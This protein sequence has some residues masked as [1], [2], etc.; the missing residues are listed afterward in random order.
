MRDNFDACLTQ[1]LE[2]E[3][4]NDD[5]PRDPGGRTSRGIIQTEFTAYLKARGQSSRDVFTMT[6]A[7]MQDIYRGQ[8]WNTVR[9]DDLPRG[10]D[11]CTFDP[12]VNSGPVR[13]V[14]WMQG[15]LGAGVDGWVGNETITTANALSNPERV[16]AVQAA[17]AARMSFLRGL[18]TFA[19][20][21]RGWSSRVVSVEAVSV[22]MIDRAALQPAQE[23]AEDQKD[24]AGQAAGGAGAGGVV[25][26]GGSLSLPDFSGSRWL[27][28]AAGVVL[29]LVVIYNLYQSYRHGLRARAY[30]AVLA[31][32]TA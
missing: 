23:Q 19:V 9:G 16:R 7:E 2:Y 24:T 31:K 21:G 13:G 15:A 1:V 12:A 27:L 10:I 8:Y 32:S 3:G 5:D 29:A 28:A 14:K 26:G 17:C 25:A 20:F 11:M 30:A 4:G 18:G 6:T 22:G